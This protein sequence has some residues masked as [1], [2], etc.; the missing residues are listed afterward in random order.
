MAEV[1][2]KFCGESS[3]IL[4]SWQMLWTFSPVGQQRNQDD[5]EM[6]ASSSCDRN[7]KGNSWLCLRGNCQNNSLIGSAQMFHHGSGD[8]AFQISLSNS[9]QNSLLKASCK[10]AKP[11]VCQW[12][13]VLFLLND[14]LH[15]KLQEHLPSIPGMERTHI[16]FG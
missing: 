14:L 16:D 8:T 2:K 3:K 5:V 4:I 13:M 6:L 9:S 11:S 7:R 12:L 15:D 1:E 10:Q